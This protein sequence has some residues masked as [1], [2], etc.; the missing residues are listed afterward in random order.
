LCWKILLKNHVYS[1]YAQHF[2]NISKCFAFDLKFVFL[3]IFV[4]LYE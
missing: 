3:T 1:A 4:F 2:Q